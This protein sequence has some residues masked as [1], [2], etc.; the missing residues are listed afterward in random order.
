MSSSSLIT[1]GGA[2]AVIIILGALA[3]VSVLL[4]GVAPLSP[5]P[6]ASIAAS[7]QQY[8]QD[9]HQAYERND[10]STAISDADAALAQNPTDVSALVAKATYLA[11]KGS[12]TFNEK[13]Y[14]AQAITVAQQALAI[15]PQS[16]EAWRV[17]GY[18]DEIMQ[19]YAAAEAAYEK[20][21]ALDPQNALTLSQQAHAF[22]LQGN[23]AKAEAGYR[24]AL[25]ID[26]T[27]DQAKMGLAGILV[28]NGDLTDALPL[29][30]ATSHDSPNTRVRAEAA[31]SAGMIDNALKQLAEAE[32][33]MQ[34]ATFIDPAYPLGWVGLGV[35]LFNE[36]IATSSDLSATSRQ[37][38]VSASLQSL[39]KAIGLNQYQSAAYYQMGV[40]L[41][42]LGQPTAAKFL[43]EAATI[44]PTDITLSVPEKQALLS[45]IK[46]AR[47]LPVRSSP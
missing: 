24:A 17:I 18:A 45:R 3:W 5:A 1:L 34:S 35:V 11:Q 39:E 28:Q 38:L 25:T 19:N 21:L 6:S 31:Y 12:L 22:D 37:S 2:L 13:E 32:H 29:Y 15:D 26:P 30:A 27:L 43:D 8:L 41:A 10:F 14:G 9:A 42:A 4:K 47:A 36:A 46:Y 33:L 44:V 23:T 16:A 7:S 20:S 40:E